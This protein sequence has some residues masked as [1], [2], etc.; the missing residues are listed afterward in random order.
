MKDSDLARDQMVLAQHHVKD[1]QETDSKDVVESSVDDI[2]EILD[3]LKKTLPKKDQQ[4]V[5]A[6]KLANVIEIDRNQV[7]TSST[8]K[9]SMP[10]PIQR[11][12][13]NPMQ[14]GGVKK[15]PMPQPMG[16]AVKN[17][18]P[19]PNKVPGGFN[20]AGAVKNPMPQPN[21]VPGGFNN[22]G[23]IKNPMPQPMGGAV[24]NPNNQIARSGANMIPKTAHAALT[25]QAAE[26][27]KIDRINAFEIGFAKRAHDAGLDKAE[28]QA[29]YEIACKRLEAK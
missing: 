1:I 22:A 14:Q 6:E 3:K 8:K 15:N 12:S 11:V 28:Y 10:Q 5:T 16:G 27:E 21:K 2:Q 23:P 20:N 19:Q 4:S 13:S 7:K 24:K 18:M 9:V 25:K 17:P 29:I 26:I